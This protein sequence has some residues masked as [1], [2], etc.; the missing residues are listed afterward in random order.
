[1]LGSQGIV[2]KCTAAIFFPTVDWI[3]SN[4][5]L[6]RLV[7]SSTFDL[8]LTGNTRFEEKTD[9][10]GKNLKNTNK[11]LFTGRFAPTDDLPQ[12]TFLIQGVCL[13]KKS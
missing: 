10:F 13:K 1:M 2:V 12:I 4:C 3:D 7:C 11:V 6:V 8:G 5:N 9:K